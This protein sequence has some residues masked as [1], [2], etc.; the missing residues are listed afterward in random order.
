MQSRPYQEKKQE[1]PGFPYSVLSQMEKSLKELVHPYRTAYL[2]CVV[3]GTWW[4][5]SPV[6]FPEPGDLGASSSS[7]HNNWMLDVWTNSFLE[8]ARDLVLLGNEPGEMVWD[9]P[10]A[11]SDSWEDPSWLHAG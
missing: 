10:A 9:V 7:S 3:L 5:L 4:I 6:Q 11:L 2:F 1:L 8:E